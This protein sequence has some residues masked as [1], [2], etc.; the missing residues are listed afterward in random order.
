MVFA[1]CASKSIAEPPPQAPANAEA[2]PDAGLPMVPLTRKSVVVPSD[3]KLEPAA[4]P[5][6]RPTSGGTSATA[7]PKAN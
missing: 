3:V 6:A 5:I 1:A 7:T 4:E 2:G